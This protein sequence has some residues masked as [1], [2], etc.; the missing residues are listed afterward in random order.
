[1]KNYLKYLNPRRARLRLDLRSASGSDKTTHPDVASFR[2][3]SGFACRPT[4]APVPERNL[5]PAETYLS[6]LTNAGICIGVDRPGDQ[7]SGYGGEGVTAGAI[8][9]TA[10]AMGAYA[11]NKDD[12]G[13]TLYNNPN[14]VLD[15]AKVYISQKSDLDSTVIAG[16]LPEGSIGTYMGVSGIALKADAI[17]LV[18]RGAG[19]KLIAGSDPRESSSDRSME[20]TGINLIAGGDDEGLQPI[21]L[22]THL[23]EALETVASETDDLR[24]VV[25]SF[26]KY[27]KNFNDTVQNHNHNS[28]FWGSPTS[29]AFNLLFEGIKTTFQLVAE[30]ESSAFSMVVNKAADKTNYFN[31]L[32]EKYILSALN[33]VN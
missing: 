15:A 14:M 10:G 26:I 21:P 7:F 13:S 2:D 9:L 18:S 8:D 6:G 4:L 5:A 12:Q 16:G 20:N 29:M 27:Q 33:H 19:I 23:L 17:R 32:G 3:Q 11:T 25:S 22:G 24:E 1:M 30:T 28:P 31:P